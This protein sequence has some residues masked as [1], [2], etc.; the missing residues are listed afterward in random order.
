VDLR[1]RA[2]SAVREKGWNWAQAAEGFAVSV[3]SVGRFMRAHKAGK[4]SRHARAAG[5]PGFYSDFPSD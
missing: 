4:V 1:E 5:G 3:A 2:V